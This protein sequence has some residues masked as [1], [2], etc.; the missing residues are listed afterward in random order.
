M[1]LIN[2]MLSKLSHKVQSLFYNLILQENP[3]FS[4]KCSCTLLKKFLNGRK[5]QPLFREIKFITDFKEKNE[6]FSSSFAKQCSLTDNGST[7]PSLIPFITDK[8]LF[9]EDFSIKYIKNVIT[10]L[11]SNVAH[12]DNMIII[13]MLVLID[14]ATCKHL[15]I[16][17]K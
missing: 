8:L 7:L 13:P 12:N 11:D 4:S 15:D 1:F 2:L 16:N 3:S 17:F 9:D 14:I 6:T 5:N 10:K